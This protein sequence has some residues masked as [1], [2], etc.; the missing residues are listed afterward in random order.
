MKETPAPSGDLNDASG[1]AAR[2]SVPPLTVPYAESGDGVLT[3]LRSS[4]HGLSRLEAATRLEQYGRNALPRAKPSGIVRVFLHQFISPLIYVLVAAALFSLAIQEWSDAGF[5]GAVLVV[6]AI[7]GTIQ[8]YTAQHAAGALQ[9]LVTST[10]RVLREGDTHEINAEELV[11]GDIVLVESGDRIPADLRLLDCHDLEVDESLLTGESVAVLKDADTILTADNALGDRINMAFAGTMVNR[12]RGLGVVVGT[13]LDTELGRIAEAVLY[14]RAAKAPLLVR[15]EKFT[16]WVAILVGVAALLMAGVALMRGMPLG[17]IFLLAVA[18]AVSAIPEGLPVALTVALAI[19]MRRMARRN[20]IVRRLVAVEALGSCTFIATD[21]TGTLTVNQ[22]TARRIA[23]PCREV[24]EVT[25]ESAEPEGT[26]VT[27][28]GTP[29]PEEETLLQL[30]C[31][32]AVLANEGFL[33]HRD[34]GWAYHGDAVDVA[35]LVMAHKAGIIKA[36]TANAF[37]E[38]ASIPFE[39]EHLFSASLNEVNGAQY[40]FVKGAL[41]R[42]LPMCST[43]SAPGQAVKLD[44][45]LLEEHVHSMAG[46]GY[47]IIALA[48]GEIALGPQEV[49]SEEHLKELTLIGLVG[50]IDPLRAE[51][52]TAVVDCREAGVEVGMITGDH[53]ATSLAIA[54][55]LE[56]ANSTEQV[57]T[58][59]ELRQAVDNAA[60]DRLTR[61]ARVFARVEPQ[62]KLDIVQSLQRNGHFVAVSGDGANDAPAMRTAQVGVAM[63]KSGTDV[64]RETADLILTD[65]NFASIVAGIEEGRIA[66]ANV[67]KVIFLLISTGTAELVLFTLA[68]LTGLPLPLLAVQLLWL[69]LVTNGIQDV[70]LAFEPAEGNEL[71]HPPR[72]PREPIFNRLMVERVV[73]SALVMGSVA[74]FLFQWLLNS[75][76][77]VDEA[78]NGTLLLMV[79]FENVHVFNCRSE[80]CSAFRLNPLRNPLLL[81]GTAAAQLVHIG[82][83]YTPWIS[84]VLRIQPV[85]GQYWLDLLGLALTVLVAIE[86]HKAVRSRFKV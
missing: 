5:I 78:R 37:P 77:T 75:G 39:S 3:A 12:G 58:G 64:A 28:R 21:K 67:R 74:F 81:F 44:P 61:R 65:D 40:A 55:E 50:M 11:P 43:M 13:A 83:M 45:S 10:S 59:P 7:I 54:R 49:F 2:V 15:M 52:K 14:K 84:D 72:P 35:L 17:E 63:G 86:L 25:G 16:Q 47:R 22:L 33:G 62:Q 41:E 69:N 85:S 20:V 27:S 79:L 30:L 26:I 38:I 82:A 53:P 29:S 70:A 68:L 23:F 80:T 57:V 66:Y 18:L 56:L 19:G 34:R 32:A 76:Y 24:W 73:L 1:A 31:R 71:R 42:L 9:Q 4:H 48:A 60:M 36:E 46:K 8:E 51:A 6:N